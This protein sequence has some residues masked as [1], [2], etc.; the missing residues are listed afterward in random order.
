MSTFPLIV[1]GLLAAV[2]LM[3]G[4]GKDIRPREKP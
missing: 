4:L 1:Q 3:A 2:F